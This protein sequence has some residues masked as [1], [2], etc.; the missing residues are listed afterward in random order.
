MSRAVRQQDIMDSDDGERVRH[1]PGHHAR[2]LPAVPQ[3]PRPP[4]LAEP[5][6]QPDHALSGVAIGVVPVAHR[7]VARP[8]PIRPTTTCITGRVQR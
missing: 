5:V 2:E 1:V 7:H 3:R 6:G 4:G 8:V